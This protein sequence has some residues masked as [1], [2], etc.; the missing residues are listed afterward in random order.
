MTT[1]NIKFLFDGPEEAEVTIVLAHGAGVPMDAPF[2][3]A[4]AEGLAERGH[5]VARFEFPFM[6]RQH[7]EGKRFPPSPTPVL[8]ERYLAVVGALGGG[9]GLV[10]GGKSLGGRVATLIA[11]QVQAKGVVCLGYPF[12]PPDKP[13]NIR[14]EYLKNVTAPTL[15]LQG[16]EDPF[17]A[18]DE[19]AEYDLPENVK[20]TWLDGGDHHLAT[21]EGSETSDE[22]NWAEGA[23]AI[24]EFVSGLSPSASPDEDATS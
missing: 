22:Q 23:G 10:I 17:G 11:N 19:V 12:H 5:R 9:S 13:E 4:F 16:A 21:V 20:I 14:I 18:P 8:V 2:M 24:A 15:I 6:Q 1:G 7:A 3:A